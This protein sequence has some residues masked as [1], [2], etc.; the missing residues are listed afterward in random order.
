MSFLF[1]SFVRCNMKNA[2]VKNTIMEYTMQVYLKNFGLIILASIPGLFGLAMPLLVGMPSYVSLGGVYLRTASIVDLDN[3]AIVAMSASV[4]VC[5][6]L[7]SF[8]IV[9]INMVIKRQRTMKRLSMDDLRSI[10]QWTNSVFVAYI[11]AMIL[12]L[13]VQIYT[14]DNQWQSV[15]VPLVNIIIGF[16]LLFFPTAMIMD[17]IRSFRALQR[18]IGMVFAKPVLILQW[19]IISLILL[20][21]VDVVS[22]TIVDFLPFIPRIIGQW[23]VMAFNSLIILPFLIVLLAQIYINKYTI[24]VY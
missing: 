15:I 17:E 2:K 4:L 9:A 23:A 5:V 8:A 14:Y 22:L 13:L 16:G 21:V 12:F 19:L 6:Y 7:M 24:L 18:S 11:S 10:A 1:C 3:V 20:S